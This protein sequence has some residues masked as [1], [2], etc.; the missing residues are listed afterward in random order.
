MVA[1]DSPYTGTGSWLRGNLHAHTTESDGSRSPERVIADYAARGYDF[2]A[3]SDHD[4]FVD[5]A[6]HREATGMALV[7]AVEVSTAGPHLLHVGARRAVDPDPDRQAVVDGI[8]SDGGFAV[9]NHPNWGESF[10]H[11]PH[12]ELERV[13]GYRGVEIYN[14]LIEQHPGAAL[15]TDRWDRLLSAGRRVW[16]FANDDAHRGWEVGRAWNVVR[17]E[18]RTPA[19]VLE[20]L[21][22]GRFY[23]ST[24][25][26]I[27]EITV[28]DAEIAVETADAD[29]LRLV[30][31]HGVVQQTVDGP[32]ATFRV[33]GD[34]VHRRESG[35]TY[36][37]VEC[38]GDAGEMAW[39]QPAFL[40]E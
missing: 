32:S 26:S 30:S 16:G 18:E 34:L 11:W 13:E 14:G 37:R 2:L 35:H 8:G 28:G 25:V 20:A 19:A 27:R 17:A 6:A 39:T 12:E 4:T 29:C 9:A 10:A 36:L 3:V 33:P 21:A 40:T 7:P 22:A 31:D 24:G 5:P 38:V 23:A 1:L 15:A